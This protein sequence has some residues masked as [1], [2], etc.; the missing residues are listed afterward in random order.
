MTPLTSHEV[1]EI[2]WPSKTYITKRATM[3]FDKLTDFFKESYGA[4]YSACAQ[5]QV[6][7]TEP[8]GA[9]YYNIDEAGGKTDLAAVVPVPGHLPFIDGF[10]Y[11]VVPASKAVTITHYGVYDKMAET[12]AVIGKYMEEHKLKQKWM[13]EEYLSD[14]D[15]EKDPTTW[16][17]NIYFVL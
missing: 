6:Q 5:H 11:V 2:A 9:I 7:L 13:I 15:I 4:I 3:P 12:Y 8:P 16:K 17:T 10:E 14:P 1:R